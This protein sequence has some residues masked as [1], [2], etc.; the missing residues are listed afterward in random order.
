MILLRKYPVLL[1]LAA[2]SLGACARTELAVSPA[3]GPVEV[4]LLAHMPQTKAVMQTDHSLTWEA[5]DQIWVEGCL[6]PFSIRNFTPGSTQATFS[7]P[8]EQLPAYRAVFPYDETAKINA[9]DRL[10]CVLPAVQHTTGEQMVPYP[11][12]VARAQAAEP[13]QLS[14]QHLTTAVQ[15]TLGSGMT[16]LKQISLRGNNGEDV[17]GTYLVEFDSNN[18]I[19]STSLSSPYQVISLQGNFEPGKT[20]VLNV[21]GEANFT[22]GLTLEADFED[23][24]YGSVSSPVPVQFVPG[25]WINLSNNLNISRIAGNGKV[26]SIED[27]RAL[28]PL[29]DAGADLSRF[30]TGGEI[31]LDCD[32]TLSDDDRLSP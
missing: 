29:A 12:A 19:A 17:A 9:S 26:S 31:L 27:W 21:L 11:L 3:G 1:L 25:A 2:A 30:C 14:F 23:G 18:A 4:S 8:A 16:G 15:F 20:Y 6:A 24:S 32:L 28:K 10:V 5:T 22:G 7:G 13:L